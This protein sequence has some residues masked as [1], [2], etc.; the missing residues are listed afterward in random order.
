LDLVPNYDSNFD[1][2]PYIN[3]IASQTTE[4]ADYYPGG[5]LSPLWYMCNINN[6][7]ENLGR[8][9]GGQGTRFDT[10]KVDIARNEIKINERLAATEIVLE[11]ISN[12][13]DADSAT[14]INAYAQ[15][16]IEAE[17]MSQFKEHSRTYSPGEAQMAAQNSTQQRLILRARLSDLSIEQL[18]SIVHQNTRRIKY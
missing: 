17:C 11:Y 7:G 13:M 10:F 3:G 9:F 18:K 15:D 1:I 6:W 12:G 16:Y 8:Q 2:Q 5:Y 14:H 4:D